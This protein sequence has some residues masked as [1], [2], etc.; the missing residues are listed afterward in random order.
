MSPIDGCES[1]VSAGK[2]ERRG[3]EWRGGELKQSKAS[4]MWQQN[5][6]RNQTSQGHIE[7]SQATAVL[8]FFLSVVIGEA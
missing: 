7:T 4:T 5:S 2:R 1:S 6:A 8:G 3:G